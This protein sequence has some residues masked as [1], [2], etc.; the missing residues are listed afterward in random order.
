NNFQDRRRRAAKLSRFFGVGFQDILMPEKEPTLPGAKVEV[1]VKVSGRRF[2]G[3][4]D[5]PK[6]SDMHEAI[7]KLRGLKA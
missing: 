6:D 3:F 7:Q 2:W 1:D 4:G 5:R